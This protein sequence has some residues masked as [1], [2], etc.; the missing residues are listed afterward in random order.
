MP[1]LHR[2]YETKSTVDL[3]KTG[4]HVY[5][6]H[7]T[8]DVW[9]MAYAVDDEPVKLWIPGQPCPSEFIACATEPGWIAVAHNDQFESTI[10]AYVMGPRYGWPIIP[11]DRHRCTMTEAYAMA[12]PGSLENAAAALGIGDRKDMG[13][14][15]VMMQMSKPRRIEPDGTIVWWDD[16]ERKRKLY[17]YCMNDVVVER[18]VDK[19]LL[20]LSS[21]EQHMWHVDQAINNRG[22]YVDLPAVRQAIK[23][24]TYETERLNFEMSRV[25]SGE[26]PKCSQAAKLLEWAN[27]RG[28]CMDSMDKDAIRH[29]LMRCA[30][31]DR[32]VKAL[33]LRQEAAKSSTAKLVAMINGSNADGRMRGTMQY[34]AASTGRF[35]GRRVQPQN[36][37]RIETLVDAGG[38]ADQAAIE[39]VIEDIATSSDMANL[40]NR[41][42]LF[43]GRPLAVLADCIRSFICAAPGNR[44]ISAD[45]SNI[46]GRVLAWLAGETWKI[47]AFEAYDAGT[48]PD[49]YKLTASRVASVLEK[50]E[51]TVESVTKQERQAIG[52]TPELACGYQGS[53]GAFQTMA[54]NY[55]LSIDDEQA[56]EIVNAWRANHPA[57]KQFWYDLDDAAVAAIDNPGRVFEAGAAGRMI[58]YR[59]AGS[60]LFC[61]LPSGRVLTYPY[62]STVECYFAKHQ[63]HGEVREIRR[64]EVAQYDAATTTVEDKREDGAVLT[65]VVK[66]WKTWDK[67]QMRYMAVDA[68]TKQWGPSKAYGGLLAENVTQAVARDLLT[69]AILRLEARGYPVVLHVHDECVSEVPEGFGSVAE[70]EAIM[71]ESPVW[72]AGL[73]VAASGWSGSRYRK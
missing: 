53:V 2:D 22:I 24:V 71:C 68:V 18:A 73:P 47:A 58:R 69:S 16:D 30:G 60:F 45:F 8:T 43:S 39:A 41:I 51:R 1:T 7:P 32:L 56:R 17:S 55:N 21:A 11:Q 67:R 9:C 33:L 70:Y 4:V 13:G 23:L 36:L 35:G 48:G 61:Q 52:K 27:A 42:D 37:P 26:V 46:E 50:T 6:E 31:D 28:A 59:K 15:K 72:A 34:H 38:D 5:A 10:E 14:R 65:R 57:V 49:I 66:A 54:A 62:P 3:P 19:R 12:L 64:S 29:A 40:S 25:T 44:L 20:R 63:V